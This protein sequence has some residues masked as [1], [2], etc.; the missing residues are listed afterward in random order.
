[1]TQIKT[2]SP[3]KGTI[4]GALLLLIVI[5][6]FSSG[7]GNWNTQSHGDDAH[8]GSYSLIP[9]PE[10]IRV[11]WVARGEKVLLA[12]WKIEDLKKIDT[13][14]QREKDPL[15]GELR[16][17]KG[18]L[19]SK[20]VEEALEKLPLEKK[21]FVDLVTLYGGS[22]VKADIPRAFVTRYPFLLSWNVDEK[23]LAVRGPFYSIAPWT[24]KEKL[25]QEILPVRKYFV[26]QVAE[27]ILTNSKEHYGLKFF[28]ERRTDPVLVRGEK[29]FMQTCMGCH[30][31]GYPL[32]PMA[33][34]SL[35]VQNQEFL[36]L[37]HASVKDMPFLDGLDHQA[38]FRYLETMK[39]PSFAN[40]L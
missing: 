21:A 39:N 24:S 31:G 10:S 20:L 9:H 1:M 34:M 29:R 37:L 14:T 19:L 3:S 16:N 17:W 30:H 38:L 27:I 36:S 11:T 26:P 13:Q 18:A 28:L 2:G 23:P 33:Q 32:P 4:G 40:S 5:A 15:S 25:S 12:T 6:L 35:R 8:E 7:F 22:G